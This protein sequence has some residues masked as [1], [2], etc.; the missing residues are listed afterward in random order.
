MN[1]DNNFTKGDIDDFTEMLKANAK[2]ANKL[3]PIYITHQ[4][5]IDTHPFVVYFRENN[6]PHR[7]EYTQDGMTKICFD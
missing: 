7:I 3:N 2:P 1:T 5:N 6:I 4:N